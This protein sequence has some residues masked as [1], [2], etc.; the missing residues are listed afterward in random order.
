MAY[1]R[2]DVYIWLGGDDRVHVWVADGD[3]GWAESGWALCDDDRHAPGREDAS[4]VGVPQAPMD[5]FV[6]MRFAQL[7]DEG[8]LSDAINRALENHTG[9]GGC[10]A[11]TRRAE[12]LNSLVT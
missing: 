3:D 7:L 2:G 5:E 8:V 11:L 6:V 12:Q 1:L 4:G 10:V 9:N